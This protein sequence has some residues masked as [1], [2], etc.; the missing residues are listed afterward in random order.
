MGYKINF[1]TPE[2]VFSS[3]FFGAVESSFTLPFSQRDIVKA[4]FYN[5]HRG[6]HILSMVECTLDEYME[7]V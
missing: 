4:M 2:K 7:R 1:L 3:T 5:A 6:C